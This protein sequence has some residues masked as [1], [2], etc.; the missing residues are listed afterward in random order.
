MAASA[1]SRESAAETSSAGRRAAL[2]WAALSRC[3]PAPKTADTSEVRV[4][5]GA[6]VTSEGQSSA[7]AATFTMDAQTLD[8]LFFERLDAAE[9]QASGR[10]R[11][12]GDPEAL[13]RFQAIFPRP[14]SRL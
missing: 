8:D 10:V 2:T 14:H 6:F 1:P 13:G 3:V 4:E 11:I 5:D 9:A 7:P 12:A